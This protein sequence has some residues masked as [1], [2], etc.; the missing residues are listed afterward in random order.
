MRKATV[1][2]DAR[3]RA[4]NLFCG[5]AATAALLV[6][7]QVAQAQ[8]T[9]EPATADH[10]CAEDQ[11]K[12]L[13]GSSTLNC[14]ANDLVVT[15]SAMINNNTVGSCPNDGLTHVVDIVLGITS[16]S[17]SRYDVGYFV[18]QDGNDPTQAGGQCSVAI[19]PLTGG[20]WF[21]GDANVCGDYSGG[22]VASTNLVTSA[23]VTCIADPVT[24]HL[25]VPYAIVYANNT[26]GTCTSVDDVTAGTSSKCQSASVPVGNVFV[27]NDANPDCTPNSTTFDGTTLTVT[28]TITNTDP[29]HTQSADGTTFLTDL[30][31]ITPA[32]A[33]QTVTCTPA[34]GASCTIVNNA[35]VVSGSFPLLPFGGSV[36][37]QITVTFPGGPPG[38]I[39]YSSMLSLTTPASVLPPASSGWVIDTNSADPG[40]GTSTLSP[41]CLSAVQ[42]P[43][44]LQSFD[45]R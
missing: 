33:V 22:G 43:V 6:G 3:S 38:N 14:V 1:D 27:T 19:F 24:H 30:S 31:G 45:V 39:P 40:Y 13:G 23:K 29:L 9:T 8:D 16:G 12:A 37:L 20:G 21:D 11:Y 5:L 32:V 2:K 17:P 34:G 4:C 10:R 35:N 7:A 25:V 15:S 26:S 42:L 18:G 44:K 28:A 36:Q 41:A